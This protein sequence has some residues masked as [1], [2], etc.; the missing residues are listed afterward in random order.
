MV[1]NKLFKSHGKI[2]VFFMNVSNNRLIRVRTFY[3]LKRKEAQVL[4]YKLRKYCCR[5]TL[6]QFSIYAWSI[7]F[8]FIFF[9]KN[10]TNEVFSGMRAPKYYKAKD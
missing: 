4:V 3:F 1:L 7:L 10:P 5:F 6:K 9:L 8:Y 2:N